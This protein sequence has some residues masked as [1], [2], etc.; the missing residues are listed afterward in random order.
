VASGT[1][2]TTGTSSPLQ[3]NVT[4]VPTGPV[5][6]PWGKGEAERTLF[7]G[8]L[9]GIQCIIA[10]TPEVPEQA[11]ASC[12]NTELSLGDAPFIPEGTKTLRIEADASAALK[13]GSYHAYLYTLA[14]N[15]GDLANGERTP[16]A[17]HTW[18]FN[19]TPLDWDYEYRGLTTATLGFWSSGAGL[20]VLDGDIRVKAVAERDPSWRPRVPVDE[21]RPGGG[22]HL[23]SDGVIQLANASATWRFQAGASYVAGTGGNWPDAIP[24]AAIPPGTRYVVMGLTWTVKDCPANHDCSP[25]PSIVRGWDSFSGK[26]VERNGDHLIEVLEVPKDIPDDGPY[27]RNGTATV[28]PFVWR[29]LDSPVGTGFECFASY[30]ATPAAADVHVVAEAWKGDVDL[31]AFKARLGVA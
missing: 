30:Y 25:N 20:N 15:T 29:C 18:R 4:P 23:V 16:E 10:G 5:V 28:D 13:S 26:E 31:A 19:L 1:G 17:V 2:A 3:A 6:N 21:W 8:T 12:S 24:L 7:D 22:H 11:T 9:A 27:A 14:R